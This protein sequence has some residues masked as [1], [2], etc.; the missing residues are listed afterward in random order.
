[1]RP[2]S[3]ASGAAIEADIQRYSSAC[4]CELGALFMVG[5]GV[6]FSAYATLATTD[7]STAETFWRGGLCVLSLS[8]LGKLLGLGYARVRLRMLRGE[9][10]L[11]SPSNESR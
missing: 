8:I 9:R 5:G 10:S 4:G 6:V 3:P 2:R 11:H 7:W 1:V